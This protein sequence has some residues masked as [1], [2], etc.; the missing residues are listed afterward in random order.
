MAGVGESV[1]IVLV[2]AQQV[3]HVLFLQEAAFLATTERYSW[4]CVRLVRLGEKVPVVQSLRRSGS[5]AP[6]PPLSLKPP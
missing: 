6:L 5:S 1:I 3:M 4:R 2:A